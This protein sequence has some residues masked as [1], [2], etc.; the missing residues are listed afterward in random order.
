MVLVQE[1]YPYTVLAIFRLHRIKVPEFLGF[2]K[3]G[4]A[5][6]I[7]ANLIKLLVGKGCPANIRKGLGVMFF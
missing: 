6:Q 5:F 2:L 3:E 4:S 1:L 7:N